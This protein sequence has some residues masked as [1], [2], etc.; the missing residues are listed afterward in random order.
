MSRISDLVDAY[1]REVELA[2]RGDV[3][4][5]ERVWLL[6]YSPDFERNVRAALPKFEE[7]TRDAGHGWHVVDISDEFGRWLAHHEYA[8]A[9]FEEPEE[10]SHSILDHFEDELV[11]F[12]RERL[13]AASPGDVVA[14]VG[15]GSVYPFLR[16]SS[17]INAADDA[18]RGRLLVFF[19]GTYDRAHSVFHL[20]DARDSSN[21][22]AIVIDPQKDIA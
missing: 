6:P 2:W 7:T 18:V 5:G 1:T 17:V 14:L 4:G 15:I 21:Y 8:D 20:L 13:A 11:A 22:R 9:L 10:L 3:S 19:P 12:L 16:A